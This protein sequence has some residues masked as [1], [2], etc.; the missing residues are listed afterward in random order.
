MK[1]LFYV[2][3]IILATTSLIFEV[4]YAQ[5]LESTNYK[6][7]NS[8]ID[9][10]G[11]VSTGSSGYNILTSAGVAGADTKLES[12]N[13]RLRS[14]FPNPFQANVPIIECFETSTNSGTTNCAFLPGGNGMRGVCGDPGCYDRAKLEIDDQN[15]P[16][17][18][19]YLVALSDDSFATTY[20][21]QSDHT[22]AT[23]FDINDYMTQCEIEGIDPDDTN[24][25]D[26]G[27]V[28]WNEELQKYNIIGIKPNTAYQVMV[29]AVNGD[30]TE[31][32]FSPLVSA[33]TE[34]PTIALDLDTAV[35]DT[36]SSGPYSI[37]L[38]ALSNSISTA[39]KSIWV[40]IST[41]SI[42]GISLYVNNL[43]GSTN[44]LYSISNSQGIPSESEDLSMD[45]GDGGYGLKTASVNQTSLGPLQ[46]SATFNT[47][48]AEEVGG[49]STTPTLMLFT[50]TSGANVGP[51]NAGRGR[52]RVKAKSFTTLASG[53]YTDTITF[54]A[55]GTWY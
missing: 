53:S 17:D 19:L 9:S 48:G 37:E 11:G 47:A 29:R 33:T 41:N 54:T 14:G 25:D 3:L 52:I 51:L 15:N 13:Y 26:S 50:N 49:L 46:M 10:G 23:T 5:T 42:G 6:I 34:L 7:L 28:N 35:T 18:A 38:G 20:F 22:I 31:T 36:E 43:N 16:I 1:K 27:D 45:D 40:D 30:F 21:L 4:A 24:C 39:E 44:G 8:T 2:F 12:T 55:L 32:Q